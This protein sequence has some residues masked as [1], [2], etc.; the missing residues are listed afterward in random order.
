[1]NSL[2]TNWTDWHEPMTQQLFSHADLNST[3]KVFC[4]TKANIETGAVSLLADLEASLRGS[5]EALLS[6]DV[7]RLEQLTHEQASLR[8]A[9]SL[10]W[11]K[12]P[13]HRIGSKS[14][15][16]VAVQDSDLPL[17]S[18]LRVA[19]MRVLHLGRVQLALLDH[20]QQSLR[21]V[22]NLTAGPQASYRPLSGTHITSVRQDSAQIT[23]D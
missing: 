17:A 11:G 13:A 21:V 23:E 19:G 15:G 1:M 12:A 14:D 5:H 7:V 9:L 16:Q 6:R 2:S 22:S 3:E 10:L 4:T 8:L 18:A 20:M